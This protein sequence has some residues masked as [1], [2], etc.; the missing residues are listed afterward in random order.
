MEIVSK[1]CIPLNSFRFYRRTA[2]WIEAFTISPFFTALS[3][4]FFY[5]P[6]IRSMRKGYIVFIHSV[7]LYVCLSVHLSVLLSVRMW[8]HQLTDSITKFYFRSFLITYNSAATDQKLFM[9]G[10]GVPGRVLFHFTSIHPWVMPQ[11]GARGQNPGHPS[12]VVYCSLFI[13][14]T[15]Y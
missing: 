10:M 5:T 12:K 4:C 8:L 13:Q 3:F 15:S 9:F 1:P 6:G 7:S 2:G 11:G 14:T